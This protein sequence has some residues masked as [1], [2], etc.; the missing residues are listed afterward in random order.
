MEKGVT[1]EN[2]RPLFYV[3]GR[4]VEGI[5]YLDPENI[6]KMTVLKEGFA[7]EYDQ[8][9]KEGQGIV[10]IETKRAGTKS[11]LSGNGMPHQSPRSFKLYPNPAKD[12]LNLDVYSDHPNNTYEI[13]DPQG[14]KVLSGK[15]RS[16]NPISM[17]ALKTGT[18]IIQLMI[19]G[20][21]ESMKFEV[22][23]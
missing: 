4:I 12:V 19:E 20:K 6:L 11:I 18:Y 17:D 15:L 9:I 2:V 22:V 10:L 13:F 1:D 16:K 5:E 8:N 21:P 3:D 14:K 23:K 7:K